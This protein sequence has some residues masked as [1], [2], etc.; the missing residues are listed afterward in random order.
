MC[1]TRRYNTTR[2]YLHHTFLLH[3]ECCSVLQRVAACCRVLQSYLYVTQL[4]VM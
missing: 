2:S 3:T 1:V 4:Y